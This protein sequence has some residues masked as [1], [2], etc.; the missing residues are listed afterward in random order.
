MDGTGQLEFCLLAV[1]RIVGTRSLSQ[2]ST[3]DFVLL[4]VNSKATRRAYLLSDDFS[5]TNALAVIVTLVGVDSGLSLLKQRSHP[6]DKWLD[7]TPLIIVEDGKPSRQGSRKSRADAA[8]IL[9]T[10]HELQGL[11][12]IEQITYA[13]LERSGGISIIPKP[14]EGA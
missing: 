1:F 11:E 10:A 4:L 12:R 14:S 9:T 8:D 5:A 6:L 3:G 2:I 13:V 7:S